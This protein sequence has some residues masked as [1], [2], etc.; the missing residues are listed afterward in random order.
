MFNIGLLMQTVAQSPAVDAPRPEISV[1]FVG[2]NSDGQVGPLDAP[3]EASVSV[4]IAPNDARGLAYYRAAQGIGVLAPRGWHCFGTYGSGGSTL[5]VTPLPMDTKAVFGSDRRKFTGAAIQVSRRFGDTSGRGA[6]AETIAR[7]FPAYKEFVKRVMQ[8]FD[9]PAESF[10]FGPYP[11]DTLRYKSDA[12]VEYRTPARNEGLGTQSWL[13][14]NE[15][16]IDGVEMLVGPTSTPDLLSLAVRLPA[17]QR[18]LAAVIVAQF[19]RD[20]ARLPIN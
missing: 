15:S 17:D 6:V 13:E 12:L 4:S 1:P 3:E 9:Q 19:E 11:A 7:V 5:Y 16:A 8:D 2:C 14:K 18:Q 20:A 10:Q